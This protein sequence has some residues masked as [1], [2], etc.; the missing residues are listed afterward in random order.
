MAPQED[1]DLFP[2]TFKPGPTA[3]ENPMYRAR[4]LVCGFDPVVCGGDH[5]PGPVA[6]PP[7]ERGWTLTKAQAIELL[8]GAAHLRRE[9]TEA[10]DAFWDEYGTPD[11]T[12]EADVTFENEI[13]LHR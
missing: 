12:R 6:K 7:T 8:G 3:L 5:G 4:C 11:Q 9:L 1:P 2:G 10:A 13:R